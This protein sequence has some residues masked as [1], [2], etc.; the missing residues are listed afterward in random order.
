MT[1]QSCGAHDCVNQCDGDFTHETC[2]LA[3]DR[4]ARDKTTEQL[5][6]TP[7]RVVA[8]A[9][10]DP[11][12][13]ILSLPA[14]HRHSDL[15]VTLDA[16]AGYFHRPPVDSSGFLLSN[17]TFA[18]RRRALVVARQAGQCRQRLPGQYDGPELYSEDVW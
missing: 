18:D 5:R 2:P 11:T 15:L 13:L 1:D 4:R 10:R 7:L 3:A 9:Y 16:T 12:G 6:Q 14:P 8:V 17:G